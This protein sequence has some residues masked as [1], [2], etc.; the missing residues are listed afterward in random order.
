MHTPQRPLFVQ[1]Y[2]TD[3]K[4][5]PAKGLGDFL[6]GYGCLIQLG[7]LLGFDVAVDLRNHPLSKYL[8]HA[9]SNPHV[10]PDYKGTSVCPHINYVADAGWKVSRDAE[11]ID[12]FKQWISDLVSEQSAIIP[13]FVTAYPLKEYDLAT[14]EQIMRC[15]APV[16]AVQSAF[17]YASP[18]R[19]YSVL[20][21]RTG[22]AVIV[23]KDGVPERIREAIR[24]VGK[25][26][27]VGDLLLA[28]TRA[29]DDVA[30]DDLGMHTTVTKPLHM[31]DSPKDE[32]DASCLGTLQD[33]WLLGRASS[34]VSV[35]IYYWGS[36]FSTQSAVLHD[37]PLTQYVVCGPSMYELYLVP[38]D[39]Q[40]TCVSGGSA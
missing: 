26:M 39:A 40:S 27:D 12:K 32:L 33:W 22:D 34:I 36:G 23:G 31:G 38:K 4:D 24:R 16:H 3:Y 15:I 13:V 1:V 20:H 6:R 25:T 7:E 2:Q 17:E 18:P 19:P 5:G 29:L 11:F 35:S 10:L 30:R 28:D 8:A 9:A 37:I 14:K 21:V